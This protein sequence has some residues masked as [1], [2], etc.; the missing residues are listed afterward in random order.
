M[1]GNVPCH[2][3]AMKKS[4]NTRV[5]VWWNVR[6]SGLSY[7]KVI[8]YSLLITQLF[9]FHLKK[10]IYT[11]NIYLYLF[12]YFSQADSRQMSWVPE[13]WVC[14]WSWLLITVIAAD[15]RSLGGLRGQ[16]QCALKPAL[17][18]LWLIDSIMKQ[19]RMMDLL[20]R[21][22]LWTSV[23]NGSGCAAMTRNVHFKSVLQCV[24]SCLLSLLSCWSNPYHSGSGI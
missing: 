21:G 22:S 11:V 20:Q 19:Q 2:E 15:C 10:I 3:W 24:F 14:Y 5:V 18:C 8:H 23:R 4:L 12:I 1:S 6:K 7:K 17:S 13:V 9:I 16:W